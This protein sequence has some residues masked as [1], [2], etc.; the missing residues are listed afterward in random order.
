MKKILAVFFLI[1][2]SSY[3]S[4]EIGKSRGLNQGMKSAAAVAVAGI[5]INESQNMATLMGIARLKGVEE[6]YRWGE[7]WLLSNNESYIENKENIESI[8]AGLHDEEI[9]DTMEAFVIPPDLRSVENYLDTY[10]K[11]KKVDSASS[12]GQSN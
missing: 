10:V 3:T 8:L 9:R 2:A 5:Q 7:S 4:Y 6:M 1:V 11:G 12:P